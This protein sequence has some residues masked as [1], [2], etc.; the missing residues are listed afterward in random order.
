MVD[1]GLLGVD[2]KI[3]SDYSD[4][5]RTHYR[6][7]LS[8]D[9]ILYDERREHTHHFALR[10][11]RKFSTRI[12]FTA[13]SNVLMHNGIVISDS[14]DFVNVAFPE[15]NRSFHKTDLSSFRK[16]E[17]VALIDRIDFANECKMV[18]RLI[19]TSSIKNLELLRI[20]SINVDFLGAKNRVL[21][22]LSCD[23]VIQAGIYDAHMATK[24][25]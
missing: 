8:Y 5:L 12:S 14:L 20:Q 7:I 10:K 25:I 3:E 13:L 16:G 2:Y 15:G 21:Y 23:P 18:Q 4:T 22:R 17:P 9:S 11:N 6:L 1:K 24:R 19:R